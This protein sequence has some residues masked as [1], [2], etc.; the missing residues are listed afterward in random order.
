[1]AGGGLGISDGY[2]QPDRHNGKAQANRVSGEDRHGSRQYTSWVNC[3]TSRNRC[4][5]GEP[6]AVSARQ[7]NSGVAAA[8]A[9][10]LL[11]QGGCGNPGK[12][13][14]NQTPGPVLD[15]RWHKNNS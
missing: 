11:K 5:V 7:K 15:R 12:G 14:P 6:R 1:M 9:A 10:D 8:I 4:E 13:Q 2:E 3:Q